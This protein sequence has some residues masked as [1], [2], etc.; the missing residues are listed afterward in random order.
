MGMMQTQGGSGANYWY[1]GA[2]N[3]C[4]GFMYIYALFGWILLCGGHLGENKT[5]V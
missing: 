3:I 2:I 4:T 1:Q 5:T